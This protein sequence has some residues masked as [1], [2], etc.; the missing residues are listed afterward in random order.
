[1]TKERPLSP[2]L[3][4]YRWQISN[5]LS[6]LHRLT[7]F[8]LQI[9]MMIISWWIILAIYSSYNPTAPFI[10]FVK[11][12]IIFKFIIFG[13]SFCFFYH[14][15]NGIRHLFWDAGYGYNLKTTRISG[16]ATI[17]FSIAATSISWLIALKIL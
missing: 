15:A 1:M 8:A 11:N 9:G 10:E 2:H 17:I 4:I 16:I 13:W 7:G 14:F 6:I 5:T 3:G 12:N